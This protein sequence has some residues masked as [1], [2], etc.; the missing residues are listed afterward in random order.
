M[1]SRSRTKELGDGT[2]WKQAYQNEPSLVQ[3]TVL[4]VTK[5]GSSEELLSILKRMGVD[6]NKR[7][8]KPDNKIPSRDELARWLDAKTDFIEER[9]KVDPG[10]LKQTDGTPVKNIWKF[11]TKRNLDS[12]AGLSGKRNAEGQLKEIRLL[13]TAF[14][15]LEIWLGYD[16]E[17]AER[18]RKKKRPDWTEFGWTYQKRLIPDACALRHLKQMGFSFGRDRRKPAPEFMQAKPGGTKTVRDIV[19]GGKLLP[20]STRAGKIR[21]GDLCQLRL[22]NK[23]EIITDKSAALWTNWYGVT[24][25]GEQVE[26]KS[27]VL[28]PDEDTPVSLG[29]SKSVLTRS[30]S[31]PDV[32]YIRA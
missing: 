28:K 5:I 9:S 2:F 24:A 17:A 21:K 8:G 15:R 7:T 6:R 4:E 16:H 27:V 26:M 23:G 22:N 19:L 30:P 32:L 31:S 11:S 3:R 25:T 18:A 14:D 10:P 12:P 20:F 13:K 1:R 29:L